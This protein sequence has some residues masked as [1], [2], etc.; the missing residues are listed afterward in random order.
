MARS[1]PPTPHGRPKLSEIARHAKAPSGCVS[2]GWPKVRDQCAQFGVRFDDW[3]HGAGELIF[4]KRA[5]GSFAASIGGVVISIPRQVGKTFLV[6]ALVFALCLLRPGLQVVWTAHHSST[7]GETFRTLKGF[8]LRKKVAPHV[9]KVLEF[10]E[11]IE[12]KNG[13][14]IMFGAR[15]RG[16]GRGFTNI[17]ML[18]F[19]E[20]QILSEKALSD[21]IPTQN[22]AENPLLFFMGTPPKPTDQSEAFS[23]K[24]SEALSGEDED[25]AYIEFSADQGANPDDRK[26]W[27]KANPSFPK[28][29]PDSAILRMKKNLDA[30]SFVREALGIWDEDVSDDSVLPG[31]ASRVDISSEIV[32]SPKIALDVS[33][34]RR[35]AAFGAAGRRSDG[36]LH[37]EIVDRRPGTAWVLEKAAELESKYGPI[38][39]QTR[40]PAQAFV[41]PLREAGFQVEEVSKA[42]HAQAVGQLIDAVTNNGLHHLGQQNLDSAVKSARLQRSEDVDVWG[43]RSSKADICGLV[44]VTLALGAVPDTEQ[45]TGRV[46]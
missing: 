41:A 45:R 28:R 6:G 1:T 12:F 5:D 27:A 2:T 43:R 30:E 19:D 21:M 13:S 25:T 8:A 24:R 3:Q 38:L 36:L 9:L 16:F 42:D 37:V 44:A 17:G 4:A 34:D 40:S 15:D 14:R 31:W 33:P 35:W 20:A 11:W 26:Q 18:V 10:E 46:Y 7:S 32:T 29:T 39:V 23:R 22:T